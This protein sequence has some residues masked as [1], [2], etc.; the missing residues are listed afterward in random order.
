[1]KRPVITLDIDWAPDAAI[2][3]A[4][5]MLVRHRAKATWF[6]THDS[7][8]VRRLRE[9]PDL[10]ELGIHPN[11]L[12]GSSHGA[13]PEEVLG[14]CMNLVPDAVSMR[15]HA[16]V[17]STPLFDTVLK[18]TPVRCDA[19]LLLPHARSTEAVEYQWMGTTM[20]RVPYHWED[21][22]EMLR[23][24]PSWSLET[25]LAGEGLR[26]F[27]FHPIHVFLNSADMKPYEALKSKVKPLG[28]ATVEAMAP[29]VHAGEGART[30]F[31]AL[32][33][34]V[35]KSGGGERVRDVYNSWKEKR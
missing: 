4:A 32:V 12:P 35:G 17:Q 30:V 25:A 22:I 1:M 6:L 3:F 34:H 8:A 16:L 15:T 11:F 10:F 29:F 26:V 18:K 31:A 13:T 5:G 9:H 23:D 2:D 27:D 21:D 28:A 33:E 14:F 20:L 7:P 24:R 19:S